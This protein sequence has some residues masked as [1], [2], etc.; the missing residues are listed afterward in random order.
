[1]LVVTL[2]R[3]ASAHLATSHISILSMSMCH[4]TVGWQT[5]SSQ[6]RGRAWRRRATRER[7]VV[8]AVQR[9]ETQLGPE[10]RVRR[11]KA[12][13][14]C[15]LKRP[16]FGERGTKKARW[17][18]DCKDANA[19]DPVDVDSIDFA[20]AAQTVCIDVVANAPERR[21][22]QLLRRPGDRSEHGKP[23]VL[24]FCMPKRNQDLCIKAER[25]EA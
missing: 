23:S 9:R 20:K 3:Q 7:V 5:I 25:V 22:E 4:A 13:A 12:N 17:C 2:P 10:S 21:M 19:E 16:Y 1:M 11:T 18:A 15:Q 6:G 24:D 14:G 8:Q